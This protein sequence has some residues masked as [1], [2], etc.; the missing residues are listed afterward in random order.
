MRLSLG[1][2]TAWALG[3]L[4]MMFLP[5]VQASADSTLHIGAGAGTACAMG[6]AGDPNAI[7]NGNTIDIFQTSGGSKDTLGQPQLLILGI[8]NDTTNLFASD[9]ISGVTY[10]NPYPGGTSISGSSP[11]FSFKG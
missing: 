3:A 4:L 7:G 5:I 10:I 9:P 2:F 1:K 8:P 11:S 6:C